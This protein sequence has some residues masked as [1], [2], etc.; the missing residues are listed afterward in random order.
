[1]S[2]PKT[3]NTNIDSNDDFEEGELIDVIDFT[4]PTT[5]D[6]TKISDGALLW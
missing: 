2:L 4:S 6:P 3:S 5:N 1:M